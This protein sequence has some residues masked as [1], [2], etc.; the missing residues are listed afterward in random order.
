MQGQLSRLCTWLSEWPIGW[1]KDISCL[2]H[3]S[4]RD[5]K[6]GWKRNNRKKRKTNT[7]TET[8]RST[9]KASLV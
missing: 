5:A 1:S 9:H 7:I 2:V 8:D 3:G 6:G 4:K